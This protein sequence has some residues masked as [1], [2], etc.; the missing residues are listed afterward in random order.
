MLTE[1]DENDFLYDEPSPY[2]NVLQSSTNNDSICS[3]YQIDECLD[4][5]EDDERDHVKELEETIANLSRHF[6]SEET[7]LEMEIESPINDQPAPLPPPVQQPTSLSISI[8]VSNLS[9][10]SG[11]KENLTD[12]VLD[13]STNN[14]KR[15]LRTLSTNT[16]V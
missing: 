11:V 10:S 9:R 2:E 12:L 4:E 1:I 16:Q 8:P 15:L 7:I 5:D 3:T 6:P 14:T 13:R